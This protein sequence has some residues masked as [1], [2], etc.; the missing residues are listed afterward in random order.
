MSTESRGGP[1]DFLLFGLIGNLSLRRTQKFLESVSIKM[2]LA[3]AFSATNRRKQ[4]FSF[5]KVY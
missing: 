2:R 3:N 1:L 4:E 5:L